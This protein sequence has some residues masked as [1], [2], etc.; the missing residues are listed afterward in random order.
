MEEIDETFR[1]PY[2]VIQSRLFAITRKL[3]FDKEDARLISHTHTQSSCDG[4]A[5]H[6]LNRFPRFVEYV[7]AGH[8]RIDG[9]MELIREMT[10]MERW[11]GHQRSGILN[12]FGCMNR[13][14]SL[15]RIHG[16]SGVALRNTNHWMRAGTYGWLAAENNCMTICMTNTTPNM[17]PWGGQ[18]N[19]IGNNPVCLAVPRNNGH[20]VLD[21]A[22]SQYSYGKM[23]D[24]ARKGQKLSYPGGMDV[25][26]KLTDDPTIILGEGQVLPA[27]L[28]KG[29]GLSILIDMMVSLL[30]GGL[31]SHEIGKK[32][33][34]TGLSQLFLCID[35]NRPGNMGTYQE[36]ADDIIESIHASTTGNEKVYYPGERTL[37]RRA[38]NM[39]KGVPV[40]ED[41]WRQ[42][43]ELT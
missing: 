43:L 3:G 24:S 33:Y 1:L 32:E 21:M 14:I 38:E 7:Q 34:E 11:D 27:G 35:L 31:S 16:I 36:T 39:E 15:A 4:V 25:Q 5:S 2:D 12:A 37:L 30:S 22:T 9:T 26:G 18:Q 8:I 23:E 13:A 17:A 20:I 40:D 41:V 19:A 42:I 10:T 29:S 28:W 6:G